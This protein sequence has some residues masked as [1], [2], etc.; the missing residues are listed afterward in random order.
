MISK[1]NYKAM[2]HACIVSD[3]VESHYNGVDKTEIFN[4]SYSL[5]I[6]NDGY[7][8]ED[9]IEI[10]IEKAQE[11]Q[12]EDEEYYSSNGGLDPAFSSWEE[13]NRQFI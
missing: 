13:C 2:M 8:V 12:E 5:M 4:E 9:I 6:E 7:D 10:M 1:K 3:I 11:Q